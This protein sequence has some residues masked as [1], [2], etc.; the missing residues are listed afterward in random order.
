MHRLLSSLRSYLVRPPARPERNERT[1]ER[2]PTDHRVAGSASC[3]ANNPI[4]KKKNKY[5]HEAVKSGAGSTNS[6]VERELLSKKGTGVVSSVL[7]ECPRCVE[8]II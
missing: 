7:I 3:D 8:C 2:K 5:H 6:I 1:N 4:R